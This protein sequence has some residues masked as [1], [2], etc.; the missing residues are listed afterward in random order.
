MGEE[1]A[2]DLRGGEVERGEG[3]AEDEVLFVEVGK[4]GLN[5]GEVGLD[6]GD[7]LGCHGC[8]GCV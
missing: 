3:L 2:D 4:V 1:E 8:G 6:G 5:G 7:E